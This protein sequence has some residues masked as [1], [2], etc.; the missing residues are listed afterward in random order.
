VS[1]TNWR[2]RGAADYNGDG[3][4]DLR[5]HHQ[6]AGSVVVWMMSG[7]IELSGIALPDLMDLAPRGPAVEEPS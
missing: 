1:D 2:I 6:T 4:A 5:W 3:Q 7:T